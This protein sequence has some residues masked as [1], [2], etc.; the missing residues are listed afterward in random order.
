MS[1]DKQQWFSVAACFVLLAS[2][3]V[4]AQSRRPRMNDS[5]SPILPTPNANVAPATPPVPVAAAPAMIDAPVAVAG[6]DTV[7]VE[8][9]PPKPPHVSGNK[10]SLTIDAENST[11][12]SVLDAVRAKTGATIDIPEE[13]GKERVVVRLGPGSPRDVLAALFYGMP[14]NYLIAGSDTDPAV[15]TSVVLTKRAGSGNSLG[16]SPATAAAYGR[17]GAPVVAPSP[18]S[19]AARLAEEAAAQEQA[20]EADAAQVAAAEAAAQALAV[21]PPPPP[22]DANNGRPMDPATQNMM[23]MFQQRQQMMQQ[24]QQI[25]EQQQKNSQP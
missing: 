16:S 25:Q 23:N 15:I 17:G 19:E 18:A 24:Q 21:Q 4:T 5:R 1:G 20:A 3:L 10:D 6:A 7:E 11:L 14:M 2:S 12:A 22:A 8:E 9:N 13:L